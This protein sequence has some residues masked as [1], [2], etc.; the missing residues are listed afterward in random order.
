M[1]RVV[2]SV[3]LMS[4]LV[5]GVALGRNRPVID[6]GDD[7]AWQGGLPVYRAENPILLHKNSSAGKCPVDVDGDGQTDDDSVAYYAFSLDESLNPRGDSYDDTGNNARFY[8]GLVSFFANKAPRWSEGGI[9]IDHEGRDDFNLHSYATEGGDIGLQTFGLWL[10]QKEDFLNGGD[11]CPVRFDDESRLAV[12]ISR[13]FKGYDHARFVV[14][15]GEQFYI[16][17]KTFGGTHTLHMVRPNETRWAVY[18]PREPFYIGFEPE[19]AEFKEHRF[20]DV[21]AAGWWV[22]KPEVSPG[23]LWLKWYAYGMDAVVDAPEGWGAPPEGPVSYALW[24]TVLERATRN[25]YALHSGYAFANDGSP[26]RLN[27]QYSPV[28]PVLEISLLDAMAWCNAL[29]EQQGLTPCYYEDAEM[30]YVM[31]RSIR[32]N[33]NEDPPMPTVP[34]LNKKADGYA[35][36]D[37]SKNG[38]SVKQ[39]GDSSVSPADGSKMIPGLEQTADLPEML[40]VPAGSYNRSDE[41]VVTLSAFFVS[42]TEISYEQWLTIKRWAEEQGYRFDHAGL[43]GSMGHDLAVHAANEPV[44]EIGQLDAMV[45]CNALSEYEGR[46]PCYYEDAA[47]TKVLRTVSPLRFEQVNS[48]LVDEPQVGH[49]PNATVSADT[50]HLK[51]EADGYRL[52]THDEWEYAARGGSSAP[53]PWGDDFSQDYAWVASNSSGKTHPVGQRLPNGFGLHDV[54]GNVYEWVWGGVPDYYD[55][56]DPRG[57]GRMI[58]RGASFRTGA[59]NQGWTDLRRVSNRPSPALGRLFAGA[60]Y[61]EI[62]FRIVRCDAGVHPAGVPPIVPRVV[63]DIQP[64]NI[65]PLQGRAWR[66]NAARTGEFD[67]QPPVSK[68]SV[69]WKLQTGGPVKASPVVVDGRVY[70]GSDGGEFY[71][72]DAKTGTAIWSFRDGGPVRPS[73]L[74]VSGTVFVACQKG[75]YALDA[76]T[77]VEKWHLSGGNDFELSPV[78]AGGLVFWQQPWQPLMGVDMKTGEVRWKHRDGRG[79]GRYTSSPAILGTTIAWCNGSPGSTAADLRTERQKWRY[80]AAADSHVYTPALRDGRMVAVGKDG[81]VELDIETGNPVWSFVQPEWDN[82]HP[83][84]SSPAVDAERVYIGHK[85]GYVYAINR[86]DGSGAWKYLTGGQVYSSPAVASGQVVIGGMDGMIR[87]LNSTTGDLLWE[88]EV[89]A[90]I[91]S[92]PALYEGMVLVGSDDGFVYCLEE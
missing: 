67:A 53:F 14:R 59:G 27:G 80:D 24:K 37:F 83:K 44:T 46:T 36:S 5:S 51:W 9:N 69:R 48:F 54:I 45:W 75:L 85:D 12:Y 8:G 32:R 77:G 41:A 33:A 47:K 88:F 86:A 10:W 73:A 21:T 56:D 43:P 81:V 49:R 82:R 20:S 58:P 63:F 39:G 3:V 31:R 87:G 2:L 4:L 18:N 1:K 34:V 16:S 25:Q 13:Y 79:V 55:A 29:S 89:G 15:D 78:A 92:S 7:Y 76:Q 91:D 72:L 84:F 19:E 61:P 57:D 60:A 30:Q 62:G 40:P 71:A 66:G 11:Q 68:P 64:E 17:E 70:V 90:P 6:F 52:P 23:A 65:D 50:P 35:V 74:V 22:T 42:K 38:F 26:G 28:A